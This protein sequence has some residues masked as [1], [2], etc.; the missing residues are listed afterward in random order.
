MASPSPEPGAAPRVLCAGIAV[1]DHVYQLGHFPAPGTK[2]RARDFAVACGGCAANEAIAAARLGAHTRLIAPL[3]DDATGDSILALLARE[4]IDC[5]GAIRVAGARSSV[6]AVLVD[7]SGER[8]IVNFRDEAL[9]TARIADPE[10]A[11]AATDAVLVDNRFPELV[12]P[13][14]QAARRRGLPV[15]LDADA[16]TRLTED[17]FAA[18]THIVF[19]ADGLRA[20][21]GRDDLVESLR[22]IAPLTDARLVVTDGPRGT[23]WLEG[24]AAEH[25]P[26]FPVRA[27]DTLGAGDVFHGAFLVAVARNLPQR[28]AVRFSAAAAA[29]KCTRF[30]GISGAPTAVEVAGF[31]A[32]GK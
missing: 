16:P 28:E 6:S 2:N 17:L 3:G 13:L 20:T 18:C 9:S 21:T 22:Q 27:V 14:A 11:L 30:G 31:L 19:S 10:A 12:L 5:A 1:V 8:A 29:I 25:L 15:V 24:D 7:P 32:D 26:A 4:G 23:F